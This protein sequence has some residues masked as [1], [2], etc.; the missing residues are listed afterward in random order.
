MQRDQ[1]S[2]N[3]QN[4]RDQ[5]SIFASRISISAYLFYRLP[6]TSFTDYRLSFPPAAPV[7]GWGFPIGFGKGVSMGKI[8]LRKAAILRYFLAEQKIV[9]KCCKKNGFHHH[10][11]RFF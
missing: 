3:P 5:R 7:F 2:V 1:I 9:K 10:E 8:P 6:I 11:S 4:Q